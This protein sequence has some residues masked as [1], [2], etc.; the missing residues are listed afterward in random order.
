MFKLIILHLHHMYQSVFMHSRSNVALFAT[1]AKH[2]VTEEFTHVMI[3]HASS[4]D[5][6]NRFLYGHS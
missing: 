6:T 2:T 4:C 5:V 3:R 1:F